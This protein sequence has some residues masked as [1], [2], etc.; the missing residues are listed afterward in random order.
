MGLRPTPDVN[1]T[2]EQ[3]TEVGKDLMFTVGLRLSLHMNFVQLAR[4]IIDV[5]KDLMFAVGLRLP[6]VHFSRTVIHCFGME[7]T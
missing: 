2:V 5:E 4:G 1:I 6:K 3:G 7:K